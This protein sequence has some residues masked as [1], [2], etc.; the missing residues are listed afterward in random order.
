MA[1]GHHCELPGDNSTAA[2]RDAQGV[3]LC[4]ATSPAHCLSMGTGNPTGIL[5]EAEVRQ[6]YLGTQLAWGRTFG[7]HPRAEMGVFIGFERTGASSDLALRFCG[8][9]GKGRRGHRR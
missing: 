2:N 7:G 3:T 9:V 1:K 5:Q 8:I 6:D 4:P